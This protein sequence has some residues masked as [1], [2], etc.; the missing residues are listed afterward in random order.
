MSLAELPTAL[1]NNSPDG[2]TIPQ[3]VPRCDI[4]AT[5]PLQQHNEASRTRHV[6]IE[7]EIRV[8]I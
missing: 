1:T 6:T 3:T 5:M 4:P 7:F 2:L 8:D